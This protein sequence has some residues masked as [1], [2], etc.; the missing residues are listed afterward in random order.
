MSRVVCLIA[1]LAFL[2]PGAADA[3]QA[4]APTI[5]QRTAGLERA[6]GFVPFYWD[7]A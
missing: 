2:F 1:V 3:Q 6:D 4:P 5:A 7:A